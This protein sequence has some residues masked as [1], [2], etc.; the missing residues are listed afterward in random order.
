MSGNRKLFME[1]LTFKQFFAKSSAVLEKYR[2][3]LAQLGKLKDQIE[4]QFF[5]PAEMIEHFYA[6][7]SEYFTW[8]ELQ[9]S[10]I[11]LQEAHNELVGNLMDAKGDPAAYQYFLRDKRIPVLVYPEDES[12]GSDEEELFDDETVEQM[13]KEI[14]DELAGK[15]EKEED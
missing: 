6:N 10:I 13:A 5:S 14:V 2:A 12:D 7:K 15:A 9:D 8:Q 3:N 11:N 1:E 4:K